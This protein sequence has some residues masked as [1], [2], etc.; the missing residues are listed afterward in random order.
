MPSP[1]SGARVAR[2]AEQQRDAV[3]GLRGPN[4]E[5]RVEFRVSWRTNLP[6]SRDRLGIDSKSTRNRLARRQG[7]GAALIHVPG[8]KPPPPVPR[9]LPARGPAA[10]YPGP[11]PPPTRRSSTAAWMGGGGEG[12]WGAA[13]AESGPAGKRADGRA[14][15]VGR[16]LAP[17]TRSPP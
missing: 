8:F 11:P 14:G 12:G 1:C 5:I 15:S 7:P 2:G 17:G 10:P 6:C 13:R 9:L 3:S 16:L 4:H